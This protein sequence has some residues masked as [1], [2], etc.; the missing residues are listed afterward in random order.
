MASD[1]GPD[2]GL[3]LPGIGGVVTAIGTIIVGIRKVAAGRLSD[4]ERHQE[5]TNAAATADSAR[6]LA[7]IWRLVNELQE[8][9]R[10]K[11]IEIT[12]IDKLCRDAKSDLLVKIGELE[13]QI[14]TLREQQ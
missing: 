8:E 5:K 14:R 9:N 13:T 7:A 1:S 12:R 6:V 4:R 11:T 10:A 3:I 2:W